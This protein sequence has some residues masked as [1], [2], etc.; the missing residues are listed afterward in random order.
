MAIPTGLLQDCPTDGSGTKCILGVGSSSVA[1][2]VRRATWRR[3]SGEQRDRHFYV[4]KMGFLC[5]RYVFC[6]LHIVDTYRNILN[7]AYGHRTLYSHM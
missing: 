3:S 7:F 4:L 5:N 2:E 6:R 1:S